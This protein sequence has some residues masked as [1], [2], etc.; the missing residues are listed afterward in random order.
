MNTRTARKALVIATLV[1]GLSS[2]STAPPPFSAYADT[3][4]RQAYQLGLN[5]NDNRV[6]S[7]IPSIVNGRLYIAEKRTSSA[8]KFTQECVSRCATAVKV[9]NG[10]NVALPVGFRY[11]KGDYQLS[12]STDYT[13][14]PITEVT[15]WDPIVHAPKTVNA[16][17]LASVPF[18]QSL[19]YKAITD[20][21]EGS[22]GFVSDYDIIETKD[23]QLKVLDS[24]EVSF[25]PSS[26]LYDGDDRLVVPVFNKDGKILLCDRATWNPAIYAPR[27]QNTKG[28]LRVTTVSTC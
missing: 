12:D 20:L 19:A 14:V 2:C 9:G 24:A 1:A 8:D 22:G 6:P 27:E 21:S 17:T 11:Q 16:S 7:N 3:K 4:E 15:Y 10:Y 25:E 26:P 13:L 28:L 23:G 5:H 18:P